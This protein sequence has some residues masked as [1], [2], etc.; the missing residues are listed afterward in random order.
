MTCSTFSTS[1][2]YCST[3]RQFRSVWTTTLATLRW[4]KSSP[5]RRPTISLAG[6]RLSAQPI[7]RYFGD[8]CATSDEKKFGSRSLMRRAHARLLSKSVV[9]RST[10]GHCRSALRPHVLLRPLHELGGAL[11]MRRVGN[12]FAHPGEIGA[13]ADPVHERLGVSAL[14]QLEEVRRV[15]APRKRRAIGDLAGAEHREP[16]IE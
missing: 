12:P 8:C 4:T 13:L 15:V 11:S 3:D 16:A 2:A 1:T 10:S 7:Q 5:G 14:L 6:T 9:S